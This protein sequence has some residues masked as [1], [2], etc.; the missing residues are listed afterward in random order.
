MVF[1]CSTYMAFFTRC[2]FIQSST[3]PIS[4]LRTILQTHDPTYH[5]IIAEISFDLTRSLLFAIFNTL[6][7]LVHVTRLSITI[8]HTFHQK[9]KK[10]ILDPSSFSS[11]DLFRMEKCILCTSKRHRFFFTYH[12]RHSKTIVSMY[13]CSTFLRDNERSCHLLLTI[14][15]HPYRYDYFSMLSYLY[16]TFYILCQIVCYRISCI[17]RFKYMGKKQFT[18]KK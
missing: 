3:Y 15:N 16:I 13:D 4:P 5:P 17:S 18:K 10:T 14:I 9:K 2:H 1:P 8:D 12:T 11:I 6:W 7:W